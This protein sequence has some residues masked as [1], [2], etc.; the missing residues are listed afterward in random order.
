MWGKFASRTQQLFIRLLALVKWANSAS[1]VCIYIY[2]VRL[3]KPC[4][5]NVVILTLNHM[6]WLYIRIV[7]ATI[8]LCYK[9]SFLSE[10]A[11]ML[12]PYVQDSHTFPICLPKI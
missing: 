3:G 1:K 7:V 11:E 8:N 4:D 2:I 6:L 10:Y 12:A 9:Q 5:K